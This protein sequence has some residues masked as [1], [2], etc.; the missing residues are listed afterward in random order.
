MEPGVECVDVF[1]VEIHEMVCCSSGREDESVD[2]VYGDAVGGGTT[3]TGVYG[4]RY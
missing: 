4:L 2:V 3:G 1:E